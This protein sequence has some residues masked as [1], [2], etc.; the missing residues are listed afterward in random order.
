MHHYWRGELYLY[1]QYIYILINLV[2]VVEIVEKWRNVAEARV[3][4][5]C[6]GLYR[7]VAVYGD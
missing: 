5:I 1:T 4:P 2:V 7:D 3:Y 6:G